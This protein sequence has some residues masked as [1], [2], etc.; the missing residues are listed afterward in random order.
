ME[1]IFAEHK[2]KHHPQAVEAAA[3]PDALLTI[4]TV[5]TLTSLGKSTIR[6]MVLEGTFPPPIRRGTRFVRWRAGDVR[7]FLRVGWPPPV[8]E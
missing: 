5:H 4:E 2:R 8:V 3:D 7:T 1:Q 6:R